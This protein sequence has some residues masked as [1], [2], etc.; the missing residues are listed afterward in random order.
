MMIAVIAKQK[1]PQKFVLCP[2]CHRGKLIFEDADTDDFPLR[3]ILPGGKR[4][5]KYHVKCAICRNQVGISF[6]R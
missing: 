5:A 2:V 3:L 6:K 4:K 1:K